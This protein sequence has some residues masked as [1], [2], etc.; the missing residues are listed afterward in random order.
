MW[1]ELPS[2]SFIGTELS[3]GLEHK[4]SDSTTL[5]D[6][7]M[8]LLVKYMLQRDFYCRLVSSFHAWRE[9]QY[10]IFMISDTTFCQGGQ[11]GFILFVAK[12]HGVIFI[13]INQGGDGILRCHLVSTL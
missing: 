1:L 8:L 10:S 3:E 12:H 7:I 6:R 9:N 13:R 11:K 2:A 4:D 5:G